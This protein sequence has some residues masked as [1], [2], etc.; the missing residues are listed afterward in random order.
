MAMECVVIEVEV[1][2]TRAPQAA[3][4]PQVVLPQVR[5]WTWSWISPGDRKQYQFS[6]LSCESLQSFILESCSLGSCVS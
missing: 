5:P 2:K 6:H 4:T 1:M 3:C